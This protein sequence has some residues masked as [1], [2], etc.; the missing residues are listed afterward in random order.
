MLATLKKAATD[1]KKDV[2]MV[3]KLKTDALKTNKLSEE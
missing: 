2:K 1:N 3:K